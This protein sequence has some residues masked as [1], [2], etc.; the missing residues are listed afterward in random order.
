MCK[1]WIYFP[2]EY[3]FID[4]IRNVI[5]QFSSQLIAASQANSTK[6]LLSFYFEEGFSFSFFLFLAFTMLVEIKS[7]QN[8]F[9][10]RI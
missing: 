7:E 6:N 5:H 9:L 8:D 1:S 10:F 2:L 4:S 3:Y